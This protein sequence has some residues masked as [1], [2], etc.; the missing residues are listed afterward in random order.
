M[1]CDGCET[2]P[3]MSIKFCPRC[4]KNVCTLYCETTFLG[5]NWANY[6]CEFC[7]KYLGG[8]KLKTWRKELSGFMPE[9]PIDQPLGDDVMPF[10]KYKG[11][12]L[13][14]V[15]DNYLDWLAGQDWVKDRWPVV[16]SYIMDNLKDIHQ[17]IP[18]ED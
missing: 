6:W 10:G 15:P 14:E 5:S 8:G 12:K 18:D 9:I 4:D 1:R 16:W 17:G 3:S 13:D 11:K 7:Y 2:V